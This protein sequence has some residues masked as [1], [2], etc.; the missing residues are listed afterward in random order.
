MDQKPTKLV[1]DHHYSLDDYCEHLE[2][3]WTLW[4]G[5]YVYADC[6]CAFRLWENELRSDLS[7]WIVHWFFYKEDIYR[8]EETG[9]YADKNFSLDFMGTYDGEFCVSNGVGYT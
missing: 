8:T 6:C 5:L 1:V 7:A 2:A 9:V 3:F 4:V